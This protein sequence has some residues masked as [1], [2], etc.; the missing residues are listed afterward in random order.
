MATRALRD[1]PDKPRHC[2]EVENREDGVSTSSFRPDLHEGQ[3]KASPD[4][5]SL[6]TALMLRTVRKIP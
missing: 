6:V 1:R 5:T 3:K 4:P 2:T